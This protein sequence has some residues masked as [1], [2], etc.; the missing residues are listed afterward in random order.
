MHPFSRSILYIPTCLALL[1]G[2]LITS[3]QEDDFPTGIY[4]YQVERLLSTDTM[5][6][7]TL[8]SQ[9]IDGQLSNPMQCTDSVKLLFVHIMDSITVS[10]LLPQADCMAFDT[11]S[12]GN[13]SASVAKGTNRFTDTLHFATGDFWI[14]DAITSKNLL[15]SEENT[16]F[17][18]QAD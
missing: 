10:R 8:T 14:I 16:Q 13:A 17:S 5:K 2:L 18:Y 4:D 15:F 3:C 9:I 6:T 11:L 12:L 7:W 1:L